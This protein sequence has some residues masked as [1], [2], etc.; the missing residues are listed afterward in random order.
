MYTERRIMFLWAETPVH[1]GSG[2][3]VE[4]IDLP[5]QREVFTEL[6]VI[7]GQS[8]KGSIREHLYNKSKKQNSQVNQKVIEQLF[9]SEGSDFAG[10]ISITQARVLA[11]PVASLKGVFVYATSPLVL[12]LF[13]RDIERLDQNFAEKLIKTSSTSQTR[14]ACASQNLAEKLIKTPIPNFDEAYTASDKVVENSQ[15]ILSQFCFKATVKPEVKEIAEK[16]SDIIFSNDSNLSYWKGLFTNNFVLLND[17]TFKHLT[18]IKTELVYRTKIN[19]ETGTV[20]KGGLWTEEY[21][22]A[23]TILW[24]NIFASDPLNKVEG[25][26]S[27]ATEVADYLKN[28]GLKYITIGGDQSVGKGFVRLSF[29]G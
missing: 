22:P 13:A 6:P 2:S 7:H 23:E 5:I 15:L 24:C 28:I 9:S 16:L 8:I 20:T 18:K 17:T 4:F 12:N 21:L 3:S 19:Y 26:L 29:Y 27:T 25:G 11:F 10:A 14:T 1:A